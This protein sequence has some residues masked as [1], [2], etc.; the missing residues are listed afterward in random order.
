MLSFSQIHGWILERY[1][2]IIVEE[3]VVKDV[4]VN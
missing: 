1:R 2:A 3:E 4:K